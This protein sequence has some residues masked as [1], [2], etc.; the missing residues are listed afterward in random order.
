MKKR[1]TMLALLLATGAGTCLQAQE[2]L[3]Q[4]KV[5]DAITVRT[6]IMNDSI[7]P[8][9]EKYADKD[10]L[11]TPV[12][13]DL[14]DAPFQ[15]LSTDTAGVLSFPKAEK[16]HSIYLLET[17]LRAER[18]M[19]GKLKVTSPARWE[20]FI[21]GESKMSKE[22][23]EDSISGASTRE[24]NLRLEP[25]A[26][27][28]I[29]IKLLSGSKDKA[30]PTLKCELIK[31]DKFKDITCFVSPE[32][33]KRFALPNTVYGNRVIGVSISPDG[34]YLLTRYW[35]NH[36]L[37]RSYTY[38]TLSE[39]KTGKVLL[40]NAKEGMRWMPKAINCIIPYRLPRAT[41]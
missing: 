11:K 8:K 37:K 36:S 20:I 14:A 23:A 40:S 25:E 13:L 38:T 29:T 39:L 6:P 24:V 17:S 4:F 12:V 33:K 19:T 31:D 15:V 5:R 27:Y 41:M 22:N 32:Q 18:F 16:D 21:N 9:G 7:N 34:K 2:K 3:T 30:V 1:T 35:N 28:E 26:D 10:L